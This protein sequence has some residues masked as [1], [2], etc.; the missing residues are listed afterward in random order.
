MLHGVGVTVINSNRWLNPDHSL[1]C[2]AAVDISNTELQFLAEGERIKA[3]G[4]TVEYVTL[5]MTMMTTTV[6]MTMMLE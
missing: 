5:M 6:I 4:I 2:S 1:K 3:D